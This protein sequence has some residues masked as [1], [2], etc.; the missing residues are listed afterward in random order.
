MT[1][2]KLYNPKIPYMEIATTVEDGA[3][4]L[5]AGEASELRGKVGSVLKGAKPT[6]ANITKEIE[7]LG[8]HSRIR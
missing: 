8:S 4:K 2:L 1:V 7:E 5:P 6:K 3:W